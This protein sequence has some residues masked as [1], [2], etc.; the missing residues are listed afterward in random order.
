MNPLVDVVIPIHSVHRPL[1]RGLESCFDGNRGVRVTV[2]C[3][4]IAEEEIRGLLSRTYPADAL[5]FLELA[6]GV[7]SPAGPLDLGV[8]SATADFIAVMGSDDFLEPGA[9]D[10]WRAAMEDSGADF[11]AA[12]LRTEN[13]QRIGVPRVRRPGSIR[14]DPAKDGFAYAT[15][16][17]GL[18]RRSALEATGARYGLGLRTGEDLEFGLKL[19]FSGKP[20]LHPEE[21]F[22]VIGGEAPDRV[23]EIRWSIAECL[24]PLKTLDT[25]WFRGL[26]P[27]WR[28]SIS[29]KLWRMNVFAYVLGR[30]A[31]SRVS[32]ED[33][34]ALRMAFDVLTAIARL[35]DT[36]LSL[37]EAGFARRLAH[38]D[39]DQSALDDA[40]A[41]FRSASLP[42]KLITPRP[43][44]LLAAGSP[45]RGALFSV[46]TRARQMGRK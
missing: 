27:S 46:M 13:G 19:W 6:D 40:V 21:P 7:P 14:L 12:P 10:S 16:G 8:R 23:T 32:D 5:R 44:M 9:L 30:R 41:A 35:E 24:K 2:V 11:L 38:L 18:W 39:A 43:W 25:A 28:R 34:E 22:Y 29:L 36:P 37:A 26:R 45:L 33:R 4:N 31:D 17:L 42:R 20:L 15:A 3:H 1:A